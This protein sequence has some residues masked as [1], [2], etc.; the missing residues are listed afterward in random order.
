[1]SA[2]SLYFEASVFEVD[3]SGTGATSG[4]VVP[5]LTAVLIEVADKAL[6]DR[7]RPDESASEVDSSSLEEGCF[8]KI[9]F[10]GAA[11]VGWENNG[12]PSSFEFS[13]P[14]SGTSSNETSCSSS[15]S[16]QRRAG[17]MPRAPLL[18]VCE[19]PLSAF[20]V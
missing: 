15:T 4:F 5:G 1:M 17:A 16:F 2:G 7:D 6:L 20:A 13:T 19:E 10:S 12:T 18:A 3:S 9:G 14:G 11:V 8:V